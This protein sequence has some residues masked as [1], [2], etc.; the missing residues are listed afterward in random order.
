VT[1]A[2]QVNGKL[3]GQV[4]VPTD[5]ADN[6]TV[7]ETMAKGVASVSKH[8]EGKQVRK[9]IVVPKKVVNFVVG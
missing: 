8:L 5:D 4:E 1:I 9:T 6:Q 2:I 3:R 7:V